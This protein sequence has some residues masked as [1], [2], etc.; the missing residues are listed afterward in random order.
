MV[1]FA[2]SL[3]VGVTVALERR[4]PAALRPSYKLNVNET[5]PIAATGAVIVH[6]S[7]VAPDAGTHPGD[8]GVRFAT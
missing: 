5:D 2:L 6:L 7:G 4:V 3:I 8:V 1:L